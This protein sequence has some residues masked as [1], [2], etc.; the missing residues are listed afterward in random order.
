[1]TTPA[2][3]LTR[4]D[5]VAAI[6]VVV[7]VLIGGALRITP[8]VSGAFH[9][10]GVY[11][12][13]AKAIATGEG[14]RL[15][16]LPGAPPQT[17]YPILYPVFLSLFWRDGAEL[18]ASIGAM[19]VATVLLAAA[20]LAAFYLHAVRF[21]HASRAAAFAGV[22][23]AA[24]APNLLY[25]ATSTLSELPFALAFAAALWALDI[26]LR[27]SRASP[28]REAGVGVV[29]ALPFL[30]RTA[31]AVVPPLA[32]LALAIHR[33][34]TRWV[35]V[36]SLLTALPWLGWMLLA[37]EGSGDATVSYQTDYL[38][39]WRATLGALGPGYVLV[40]IGKALA[41]IAHISFEALAREL[42][43]RIDAAPYVARSLGAI[44]CVWLL[45]RLRFRDPVA[46]VTLGYLAFVVAWPWAP[47]RFLVPILPVLLVATFTALE[48]G[49]ATLGARR[50]GIVVLASS[51]ALCVT[52]GFLLTRYSVASKA[53]SYPYFRLPDEPVAWESFR[54]AFDWLQNHS[55]PSDVV[56]AG[57]DT[58]TALYTERRS[59]RPFVPR[60]EALFYGAD[61]SLVGSLESFEAL[62]DAYAPRFVFVSPMPAFPEE[63]PLYELVAAYAQQHP[64]RA[65]PAYV[66]RDPR[67][68][69]Y[70]IVRK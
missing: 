24:S 68:V 21:G 15:I 47:D 25:Y 16:Q 40:N 35:A 31:G 34:S 37:G 10:D 8:G 56:V 69:I 14:Y 12:L 7:A 18:V 26:E 4:I 5:A 67:F 2:R 61:A 43:A 32:V 22:V 52:N 60:P 39:W 49:A 6:A 45:A 3:A 57:F 19:Q 54:D 29:L 64:D 66:G 70:S 11:A 30:V 27:A 58:M 55:E 9:D 44:P 42:Y 28:V 17:K 48:R 50:A 65:A 62:V 63:V 53:S 46:I 41:G 38:D 33:R 36:G 51:L 1:M 13:T 23:L 59:I 20:A